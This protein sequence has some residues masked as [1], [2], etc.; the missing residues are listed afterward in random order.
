M[1]ASVMSV[2]VL[3]MIGVTIFKKMIQRDHIEA[4]AIWFSHKL[5]IPKRPTKH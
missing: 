3:I 2:D 4:N 5:T 1:F